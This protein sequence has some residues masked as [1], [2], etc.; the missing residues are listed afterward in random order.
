MNPSFRVQLRLSRAIDRLS[1][2]LGIAVT[3]AC[4]NLLEQ[5]IAT[6]VTRMQNQGVLEH[7]PQVRLAEDNLHRCLR[8]F[9]EEAVELKTFP[10]IEDKAFHIVMR[11]MC[12]V[13][14]Y[15]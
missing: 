2:K 12:P 3:P 10:N 4:K 5:M 1:L 7:E 11:R 14:P 8:E 6:G 13:W 9:S 15:C